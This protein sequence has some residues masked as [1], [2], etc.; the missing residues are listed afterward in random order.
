M[1]FEMTVDRPAGVAA[2][3]VDSPAGTSVLAHPATPDVSKS[4]EEEGSNGE[5]FPC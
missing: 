1:T 5:D 4:Q 3:N 2:S